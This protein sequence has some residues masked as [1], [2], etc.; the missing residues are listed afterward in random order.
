MLIEIIVAIRRILSEILKYFKNHCFNQSKRREK[1]TND[2][3]N[4]NSKDIWGVVIAIVSA[5]LCAAID[6]FLRNE[7]NEKNKEEET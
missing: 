3:L 7:S 2:K 5:G 6:I 4:I 1:I